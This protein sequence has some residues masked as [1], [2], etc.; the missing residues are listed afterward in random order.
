MV[1]CPEKGGDKTSPEGA[2]KNN[3]PKVELLREDT[4]KE[5]NGK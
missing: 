2:A 4:R 3:K 5:G 1:R